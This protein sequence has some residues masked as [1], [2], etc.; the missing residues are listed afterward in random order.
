MKN[1]L[2]VS[3]LII[4]L[5]AKGQ[6]F[7]FDIA[8]NTQQIEGTDLHIFQTL[9]SDITDFV[10]S[11]NWTNF[12]FKPEE[13]IEGTIMI[14]LDD[15]ISSDEFKGQLNIVLR[16]P[17]FNTNY[18]TVLLNY[19]D[20]DFHIRYI[21]HQP[22]EYSD[23]SFTS[24]LTSILAFYI[25]ISLGLDADS[26]SRF[27]GTPFF[28][29]AMEVVNAA[30]NAS[31]RG[32]RS[33]ESQRNRYWLIENLLNGA[34]MPLRE[35]IYLYHRRGLDLMS[36]NM[37]MGRLAVSESLEKLQAVHRTRP[38]LFI[39]QLFLEAKREEIINIYSRANQMDKPRVVNI[40][41][42]IDPANSSAYQRIQTGG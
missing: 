10:N 4:T 32:W 28:E 29:R 38:G 17:V 11:R 27:G 20:R 34:Y 9:Q 19:L 31:E 12:N 25:Y 24:N 26:F 23:G 42:E 5:T 7:N 37:D 1:I 21:E 3:C 8:V 18:N 14:T 33:F 22:L 40:L 13:R 15:R 41:K 6:E 39:L 16:R 35:G 36:E 30:Q 2:L